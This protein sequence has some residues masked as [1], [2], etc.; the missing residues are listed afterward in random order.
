MSREESLKRSAISLD[1]TTIPENKK[2][3]ILRS[4]MKQTDWLI[5]K[6]MGFL[7][8]QRKQRKLLEIFLRQ[9][10]GK[11]WQKNSVSPYNPRLGSETLPLGLQCPLQESHIFLFKRS[12]Y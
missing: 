3:S 11:D 9:L 12:Q 5:W 10:Q 6:K 7:K 2:R 8:I 1:I 4:S